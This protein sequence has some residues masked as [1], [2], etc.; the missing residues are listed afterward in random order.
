MSAESSSGGAAVERILFSI[1][2]AGG[3]ITNPTRQVV[4]ILAGCHDHVTAEV[5]IAEVHRRTPGVAP[6]TVYRV[7]QRLGELDLLEHVHSG[8]GPAFYHLRDD[9]HAHLACSTCGAVIDVPVV[10]FDAVAA[11]IEAGFG[12]TIDPRHSAMLG[13]CLACRAPV[14]Q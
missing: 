6:S 4:D 13:R 1:Q 14:H 5:V 2:Q 7:I 10:T 11:A 12:F 3:R 8:N 9:S